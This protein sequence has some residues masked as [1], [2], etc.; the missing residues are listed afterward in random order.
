MLFVDE[1][2]R[3]DIPVV[4]PDTSVRRIIQLMVDTGVE[5]ILIAN[6][7]GRVIGTIGDEQLVASLHASRRRPWW[8][9]LMADGDTTGTEERLESLVASEVMLRRVVAVV[10]TTSAIV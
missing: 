4:S 6:A 7:R 5:S 2:M 3:H 10:P 1:L 8:R 9:Q